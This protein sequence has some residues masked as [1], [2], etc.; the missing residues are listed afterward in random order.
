MGRSKRDLRGNQISASMLTQILQNSRRV[1]TTEIRRNFGAT[2]VVCQKAAD[3]IQALFL[4]KVR[5]YAK[6]SKSAGGQLVDATPELEKDLANELDKLTGKYGATGP[7]F[8]NFPTFSFADEP[9]QPVGVKFEDKSA[10]SEAAAAAEAAEVDTEEL[11]RPFW[12]I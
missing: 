5:A 4:D 1:I 7:D 3:P 12:R 6:K 2:A 11:N 9:L 8:L 10:V